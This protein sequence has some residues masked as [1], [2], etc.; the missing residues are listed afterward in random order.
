M[1]CGF[2]AS[3]L[4][5]YLGFRSGNVC[6]SVMANILSPWHSGSISLCVLACH[7]SDKQPAGKLSFLC[8]MVIELTTS[9]YTW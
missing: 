5:P 9:P 4:R 6:P 2:T 1:F 8:L 7:I 3:N